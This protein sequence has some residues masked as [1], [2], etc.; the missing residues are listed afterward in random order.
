MSSRRAAAFDPSRLDDL[1]EFLQAPTAEEPAVP[2]PTATADPGVSSTV[3]LV[4]ASR[5][6]DGVAKTAP[7]PPRERGRGAHATAAIADARRAYVTVAVRIPRQ[8][9]EVL[10]RDLLAGNAERPSYAQVV[11]WTCEDHPEAVLEE[12]AWE[13][14][15][16]GRKPRGRRLAS[17]SVALT[18]RF[19]PDELEHLDRII[20]RT[21]TTTRKTTRT[22]AVTA[23]LRAAVKQGLPPMADS[24]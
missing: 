7:R 2:S 8:L 21:A 10:V 15:T 12:L 16:K 1:D 11:G 5:T 20:T 9:Y 19:Q 3:L 6:S 17:D 22:A 23:S 4:K 13:S 14:E 24:T 18:L